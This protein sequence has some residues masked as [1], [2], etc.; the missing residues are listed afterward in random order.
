MQTDT[1]NSTSTWTAPI[2]VHFARVRCWGSGGGGFADASGGGGGGAYSEALVPVTPGT[3]YTVTVP[4]GGTGGV[5]AGASPTD[6]ADT[7]FGT[8]GTI[9]AKGGLK[10][11]N[12]LGGAGGQASS[13]VG[14]IKHSGGTGG[15]NVGSNGGGG[16]GTGGDTT[17]GGNGGNSVAGAAGTT[18]GF[19][20]GTGGLG[21]GDP[22]GAAPSVGGGG[23]G[24]GGAGNAGAG[25]NARLTVTWQVDDKVSFMNFPK[26][27]L[28]AV[29]SV[30]QRI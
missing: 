7:W 2:N 24:G 3:I 29:I 19:V 17:D 6:G 13:S 22:G 28:R 30:W 18:N 12:V 15:S 10:G 9:L 26:F 16:G 20:G 8:S 5:F 25:G 1:F 27:L 4:V 21:A 14:D 23:G 11:A